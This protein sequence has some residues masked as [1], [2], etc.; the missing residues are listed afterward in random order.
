MDYSPTL[1]F[2]GFNLKRRKFKQERREKRAIV[3]VYVAIDF[4]V[5]RQNFKQMAK[6]ICHDN[7]SSVATQRTE[8]RRAMSRQKTTCCNRT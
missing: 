5:S 4:S 6:E 7:L 1:C 3:K 2:A 8:Y